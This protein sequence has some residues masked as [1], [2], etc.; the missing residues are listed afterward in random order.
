MSENKASLDQYIDV[1]DVQNDVVIAKDK[2]LRAILM[3]SSLNFALKSGQEQNALIYAFQGFL[4]SLDFSCQIVITSRKLNMTNYL[5]I[6]REQQAKQTNEL[7][8]IQVTEYMSFI[9]SLTEMNNIM[10]NNFYVII[11]FSAINTTQQGAFSKLQNAFNLQTKKDATF[12]ADLFQQ[13]KTQLWQRVEF[14][15]A[16][17]NSFGIQA[18]PLETQELIELLHNFYN[19]ADVGVE[20]A[21]PGELQATIS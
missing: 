3:C 18:V 1:F 14:V 11:P 2:S 16:G 4:N 6:L 5:N 19:P 20:L 10:S 12:T 15:M 13:Y 21:E 8:Q 7:L 17:L 9:K